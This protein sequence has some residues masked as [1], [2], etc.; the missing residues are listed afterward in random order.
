MCLGAGSPWLC[1]Y[2]CVYPW[3]GSSTRN[4]VCDS[5]V[6]VTVQMS[7][8][9][10]R[11]CAIVTVTVAL[12]VWLWSAFDCHCD[13]HTLSQETPVTQDRFWSVLPE[14]L[15]GP[16]SSLDGR[17]GTE[18]G[19]GHGF[20]RKILTCTLSRSQLWLE[21]EKPTPC[22]LWPHLLDS[23]FRSGDVKI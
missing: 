3:H 1:W 2:D 9:Y 23:C 16:P 5:V 11:E 18:T 10:A 13:S 12:R 15:I 14:S 8:V 17:S 19:L 4:H 7:C 6:P 22:C 20:R 21:V